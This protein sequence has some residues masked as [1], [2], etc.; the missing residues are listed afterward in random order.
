[1]L[2]TPEFTNDFTQE[3]VQQHK[4]TAI[5]GYVP[6]LFFIQLIT[7]KGSPYARF[8]AN[9]GL[10]LL[11]ATAALNVATGIFSFIM[12]LI[13]LGWAATVITSVVNVVPVLLM[14]FGIVF[15]AKNR[16]KELLVI[17]KFRILK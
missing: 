5:I 16:S 8:H 7:A 6:P 13:K 10:I 17:G 14:V 3:D 2:D 12:N 11:I 9:Q 15:T 4:V 1:M